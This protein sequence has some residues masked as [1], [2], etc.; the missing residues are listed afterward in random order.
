MVKTLK[1]HCAKNVETGSFFWSVFSA[2]TGKYG[3]DKT[4]YL[5]FF[6]AVRVM[7]FIRYLHVKPEVLLLL[8]GNI[9]PCSLWC[10][11]ALGG[12]SK[13]KRSSCKKPETRISCVSYIKIKN[14]E[15]LNNQRLQIW[16]DGKDCF[17]W[18]RS[19]A[20][21]AI[22]WSFSYIHSCRRYYL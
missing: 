6:C 8:I 15:H 19:A 14:T 2:K 18:K 16:Y 22:H 3:P 5:D 17:K 10:H 11:A 21:F 1:R 7:F 4:L 13:T 20:S 9:Q 12:I